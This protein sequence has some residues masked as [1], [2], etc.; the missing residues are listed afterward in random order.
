MNK[1]LKIF[2]IAALALLITGC[3]KEST[4][5]DFS[6]PFTEKQ[7]VRAL[8]ENFSKMNKVEREIE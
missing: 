7:V 3:A 6:K 4:E 8:E 2:L 5:L 1:I